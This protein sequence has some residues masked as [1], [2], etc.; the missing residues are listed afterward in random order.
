LAAIGPSSEF[1]EP[2]GLPAI[3]LV[4][5]NSRNWLL[6]HAKVAMVIALLL[7][8][9]SVLLFWRQ[10]PVE[11]K[12]KYGLHPLGDSLGSSIDDTAQLHPIPADNES[13][14]ADRGHGSKF[15]DTSLDEPHLALPRPEP[16]PISM[17]AP[18]HL[19]A[20]GDPPAE[21]T[22]ATAADRWPSA[23][24]SQ[25]SSRGQ[26]AEPAGESASTRDVPPWESWSDEKTSP[27]VAPAAEAAAEAAPRLAPPDG[28]GIKPA[29]EDA[30]T[31]SLSADRPSSRAGGAPRPRSVAKL[32]G[33]INKPSAE[34]ANERARR[35]LY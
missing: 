30:R 3:D 28:S 10:A 14:A 7:A 17:S 33:T 26:S 20:A 25:D 9:N 29:P 19:D 32:K 4:W 8:S 22:L 5:Q 31:A 35:S 23:T 27:A 13:L 12:A 2:H 6:K 21:P 24:G 16:D 11:H 18:P 1:F 34:P 15:S